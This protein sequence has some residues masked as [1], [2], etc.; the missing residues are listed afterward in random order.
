[1]KIVLLNVLPPD[2]GKALALAKHWGNKVQKRSVAKMKTMI[3]E[4]L[5]ERM[6]SGGVRV[7]QFKK[8]RWVIS[9]TPGMLTAP[10]TNLIPIVGI[11][12]LRVEDVAKYPLIDTPNKA[13]V[14]LRELGNDA[15]VPVFMR[16]TLFEYYCSELYTAQY[17]GFPRTAQFAFCSPSGVIM[18]I[19]VA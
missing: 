2:L 13:A 6:P 12:K 16:F 17:G 19:N 14:M 7:Q 15:S 5:L 3:G 18:R 4:F 1:M 10:G 8:I 11:R 9:L